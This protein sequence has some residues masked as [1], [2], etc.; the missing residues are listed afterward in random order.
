MNTL[1]TFNEI[2]GDREYPYIQVSTTLTGETVEQVE[3]FKSDIGDFCDYYNI[4]YTK[5][6]YLNVDE[7]N[8]SDDEKDK[9]RRLQE[10]EKIH[11][12]YRPVCPE[13][14]EKLSINWNG[15]VTLCCSD[16]DNF[17]VIGNILDS[18]I[19]SIF[20]SKIAK[21][22]RGVIAKHQYGKIKCCAECYETV[23]LTK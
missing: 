9:I 7:M 5:L 10:H 2:R 4:G 21:V 8:V 12:E 22:Y 18:D 20:T 14:F 23:P 19:K 16:Y 17:M 3:H 11:H 6:N 1:R 15:D 13:A